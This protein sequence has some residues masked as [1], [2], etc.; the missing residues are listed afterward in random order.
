M[1][2]KLI[3]D[4]IASELTDTILVSVGAEDADD[5]TAGVI[6]MAE[7]NVASDEGPLSVAEALTLAQV[8]ADEQDKDTVYI[9]LQ[10]DSFQWLPEWGTLS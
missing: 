2:L 6:W 3:S 8:M 4:D 9:T 5:I 10:P 1:H 7:G